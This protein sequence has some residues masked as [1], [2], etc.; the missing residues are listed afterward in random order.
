MMKKYKDMVNEA[1]ITT[2][3]D[4]VYKAID[5]LYKAF[6]SR[7]PLAKVADKKDLRE[8]ESLMIKVDDK[9]TDLQDK[10]GLIPDSGEAW[11]GKE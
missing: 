2:S 10:L 8:I 6:G 11:R 9:W 3:N 4:D 5:L 1:P 7:G